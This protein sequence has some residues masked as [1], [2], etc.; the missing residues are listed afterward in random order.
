MLR[1]RTGFVG[2]QR[3]PTPTQE[4]FA[5]PGGH[6]FKLQ[7]LPWRKARSL[8][9]SRSL[10]SEARR[11]SKGFLRTLTVYKSSAEPLYWARHQQASER[12]LLQGGF[13]SGTQG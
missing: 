9:V 3:S 11:V 12:S 7:D 10:A 6:G 1:H 13:I 4:A 5:P 8:G 2:R